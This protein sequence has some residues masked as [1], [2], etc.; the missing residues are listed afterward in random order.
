MKKG[1]FNLILLFPAMTAAETVLFDDFE[2]DA[3]NW[4]TDDH[5]VLQSDGLLVVTDNGGAGATRAFSDFDTSVTLAV[6]EQIKFSAEVFFT[7]SGASVSRALTIGL[8]DGEGSAAYIGRLSA[9][10]IAYGEGHYIDMQLD[11]TAPNLISD[12][13]V[14]EVFED[15]PSIRL[16]SSPNDG[17]SHTVSFTLARTGEGELLLTTS[18]EIGDGSFRTFSY[19]DN[20]AEDFTFS[21][22]DIATFG[23]SNYDFNLDEV[24]VEYGPIPLEATMVSSLQY[25]SATQR[26]TLRFAD[27]GETTYTV[28]SSADLDFSS[29]VTDY[30]L[31]GSEDVE[32]YPGE[33]EFRFTDESA[34]G[35]KH[36]WRVRSDS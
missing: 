16:N 10:G 14:L 12:A 19:L 6:G 17:Y 15:V 33:I 11:G 26:V 21:R 35:D 2:S 7:S 29:G 34:S 9:G 25:E 3:G 22:V 5:S 23:N 28:E 36:F 20:I 18:G 32:S 1:F 13:V 27:T 8:S 4:G 30:P 31:D 24:T